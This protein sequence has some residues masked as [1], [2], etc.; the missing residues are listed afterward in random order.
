MSERVTSY[1]F[2][3]RAPNNTVIYNKTFI[4]TMVDNVVQILG[5][6]E[7]T[8][9]NASVTVAN[10]TG[11]TTSSAKFQTVNISRFFFHIL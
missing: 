7:E 10:P 5:L 1:L 2:V 8:Y 11:E 6:E 9:Y 4:P 3:L